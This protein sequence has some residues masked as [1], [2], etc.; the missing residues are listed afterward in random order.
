[1]NKNISLDGLRDDVQHNLVGMIKLYCFQFYQPI[2][3]QVPIRFSNAIKSLPA[4]AY[5]AKKTPPQ[6]PN[7]LNALDAY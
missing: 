2:T 5:K 1:M 3:N 4:Q 7:T 6:R